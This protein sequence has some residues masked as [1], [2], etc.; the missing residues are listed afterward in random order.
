MFGLGFTPLAL[1]LEQLEQLESF[2]TSSLILSHATPVDGAS[3][4]LEQH[5]ADPVF[6]A[7]WPI[8]STL[9]FV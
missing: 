2:I 9:L 4:P 5:V 6:E 3:V 8:L 1:Q 7:L